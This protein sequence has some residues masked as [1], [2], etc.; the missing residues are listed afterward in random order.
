MARV[1]DQL[2][3][4]EEFLAFDDGAAQLSAVGGRLVAMTSAAR[5]W[6]SGR[7]AGGQHQ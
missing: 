2:W 6:R 7:A 4:L 1:A 5:A 3:T